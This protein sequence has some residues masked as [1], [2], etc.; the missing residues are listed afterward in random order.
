M[1]SSNISKVRRDK[2]EL[3]QVKKLAQKFT[4]GAMIEP[5]V[6]KPESAEKAAMQPDTESTLYRTLVANTYNYMD[7][8]DDVHVK[9]IFTKS[10]NETK[11][12]FLLHDH[13]FKLTS[14]IGAI[15]KAYESALSWREVG[16]D[17]DGMTTAL[18]LDSAIE[19]AKNE[20]IFNAYAN[21]EIN[22]HSVGMQYVKIDLAID[23]HQDKE[24]FNLYSSVLPTLGNAD[25]AEAQGYFFV[26]SEAKLRETSAV[27]MG[28]NDLTGVLDN[29]EKS[30][31]VEQIF[32]FLNN[33]FEN[34]EIVFNLCEQ[35]IDTF[36]HLKPLAST[37]TVKKP[38]FFEL[39]SKQ[40]K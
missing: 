36:K 13:E 8:H 25:K 15:N 5:K 33:K 38:S 19:K 1:R 29:K 10:I 28:S 7:S 30:I 17:K 39:M 3:L 6:I 21:K 35:F 27:L 9:G 12:I 22:Q 11:K 2:A 24:A 4:D 26:V 34:K 37:T 14:Q 40:I 20:A 31:D 23:D 16:L 18:L 32:N